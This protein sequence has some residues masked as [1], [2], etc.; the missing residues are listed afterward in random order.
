M[1][2][3]WRYSTREYHEAIGQMAS[4]SYQSRWC[5]VFVIN[6]GFFCCCCFF[7]YYFVRTSLNTHMWQMQW[8][9]FL[10]FNGCKYLNS[11]PMLDKYS[12]LKNSI[13]HTEK[14]TEKVFCVYRISAFLSQFVLS[15]CYWCC[16]IKD[17]FK[18]KTWHIG[19][20][21]ILDTLGNSVNIQA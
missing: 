7:L 5:F 14:I 17:I 10:S 12:L 6:S 9:A 3:N 4:S 20:E 15:L 19:N 8:K 21:I 18:C 11:C 2:I 16:Y 1:H 13:S